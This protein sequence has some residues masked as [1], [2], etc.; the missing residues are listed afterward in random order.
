MLN[1]Y[2]KARLVTAWL[3]E[4]DDDSLLAF[5]CCRKLKALRVALN[6]HKATTHDPSCLDRLRT[7]YIAL[8]S[9][10]TRPHN[11]LHNLVWLGRTWIRQEVYGARELVVRCGSDQ[12]PWFQYL[13]A[14]E[15]V[16]DIEPLLN[17]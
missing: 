11:Q 3:G 15:M 1:I 12:I 6:H 4:P 17:D 8:F 13:D 14:M 9:L 2:R 16:T 7:I 5:A 10:Y